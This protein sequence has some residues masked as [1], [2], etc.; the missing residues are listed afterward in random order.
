MA[1]LMDI[2]EENSIHPMN[3]ETGSKRLA[4]MALAQTYG[5]KGFAC[6]SPSFDSLL[7]NGNIATIKFSNASNGLTTYGKPLTGFE[8]AAADKVFRPAKAVISQGKVLV[9]SLDVKEPVAVRY[10]FKDFTI[11]ELFST[12]GFPVSSFRT[13][14]W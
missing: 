6:S 11:G 10:A 13:D 7:I 12:E 9:S 3:K 8:I 5:I 14:S 1:V 4:F 2:G